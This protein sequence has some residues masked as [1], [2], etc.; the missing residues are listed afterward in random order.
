M[1]A[2]EVES[3]ARPT[4]NEA[5]RLGNFQATLKEEERK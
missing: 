4:T 3:V 2:N 5:Y 1:V